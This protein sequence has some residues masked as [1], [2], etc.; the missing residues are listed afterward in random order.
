MENY[1]DL[2]WVE[3]YRPNDLKSIISHVDILNTLNNLINNNK[4][5][6]LIFYGPPGTGKTTT[7]LACAKKIYGESYKSIILELNGVVKQS[8]GKKY[9]VAV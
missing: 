5:P 8:P 2:P 1:T 3:K 4:L 9:K 6:H 7:I